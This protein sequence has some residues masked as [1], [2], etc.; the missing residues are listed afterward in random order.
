MYL[1]ID[2]IIYLNKSILKLEGYLVRELTPCLLP[3]VTVLWTHI[4]SYQSLELSNSLCG[5]KIFLVFLSAQI[6]GFQS[7]ATVGKRENVVGPR[8]NF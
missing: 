5:D 1:L 3:E 2:K 4:S 6:I 7:T 8:L